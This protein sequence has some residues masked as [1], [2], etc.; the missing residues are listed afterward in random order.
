MSRFYRDSSH[1]TDGRSRSAVL[2]LDTEKEQEDFKKLVARATNTWEQAP[3]WVKT[4]ND[5]LQDVP[6][7]SSLPK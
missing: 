4:L 7:A 6:L 1:Y 5:T 3:Q 2:M